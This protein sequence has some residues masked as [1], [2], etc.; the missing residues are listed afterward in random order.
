MK[1]T[2][3][4]VTGSGIVD[5]CNACLTIAADLL[6]YEGVL[7]KQAALKRLPEIAKKT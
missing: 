5:S 7:A 4:G 1:D 3:D 2:R 6:K